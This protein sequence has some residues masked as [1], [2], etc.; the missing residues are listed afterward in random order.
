M[1]IDWRRAL[2]LLPIL[3]GAVVGLYVLLGSAST[4]GTPRASLLATTA[5]DGVSVGTSKG[6]LAR[7]FQAYA[8]DGTLVRLSDLRGAPTIVNFWATWCASC[9][10][11]LPDLR[12]YQQELGPDRLNV[13]AVNVGESS[14]EAKDFFAALD[15]PDMRVGL[16]PSLVIADAYRVRG[17]PQSVFIDSQGIIRAVYV[18]QLTQDA[19]RDY[20]QAAARGADQPDDATG[21]LRIVTTVARDHVLEVETLDD[22]RLA[23]RSKSLRCDDAYCA[24]PAVDAL[25]AAGGVLHVERH[26]DV[27]PAEIIVTFDTERTAEAELV[28]ALV[29]ALDGLE[30]PLYTR[31]LEIV[32]R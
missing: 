25:A 8:P 26:L 4:A 1:L 15:A 16:D 21:P 14:D 11:E 10:V 17:M 31:P 27:D 24:A 6:D 12:D 28:D 3:A 22:G 9:A 30:D 32:Y 5:P 2:L 7:D 19:L 13:L 29:A 18:G 23:L 20:G